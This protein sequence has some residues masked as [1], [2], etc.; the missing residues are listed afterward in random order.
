MPPVGGSSRQTSSAGRGGARPL[1]LAARRWRR[2]AP[3]RAAAPGPGR[4]APKGSTRISAELSTTTLPVLGWMSSTRT[5]SVH[6]ALAPAADPPERSATSWRPSAAVAVEPGPEQQHLGRTPRPRPGRWRGRRWRSSRSARGAAAGPRTGP[7]TSARPETVVTVRSPSRAESALDVV[8][9]D[10]ARRPQRL[11]HQ[12]RDTEAG[13]G[14]VRRVGALEHASAS[15]AAMTSGDERGWGEEAADAPERIAA[16]RRGE[17]PCTPHATPARTAPD[18][19]LRKARELPL[20]SVGR[21]V[22]RRE[23]LLR[24]L[25]DAG[26]GAV[27]RRVPRRWAR[28]VSAPRGQ[29]EGLLAHV[30]GRAPPAR[31]RGR[32]R[33]RRRDAGQPPPASARGTGCPPGHRA[34]RG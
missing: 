31:R 26:V 18:V 27:R 15:S 19:G 3:G 29:V 23:A 22:A 14:S 7:Q 20:T 32:A 34:G 25:V 33:R 6:S 30:V 17:L 24:G 13:D 1:R 21:C 11:D 12:R 4:P 9:A 8:L 2:R 16:R 5:R 10:A 28:S